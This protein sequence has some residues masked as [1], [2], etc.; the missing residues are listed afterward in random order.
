MFRYGEVALLSTDGMTTTSGEPHHTDV[1]DDGGKRSARV[2]PHASNIL[3]YI[4]MNTNIS[5]CKLGVGQPL[6]MS[7]SCG[8]R[9]LDDT[10]D[11][12]HETA[13]ARYNN[14]TQQENDTT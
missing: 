3:H 10:S 8:K 12:W 13:G 9:N 5:N 14:F 6:N 1:W 4:I 11:E 2:T 7:Q